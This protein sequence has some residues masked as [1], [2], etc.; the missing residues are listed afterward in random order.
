MSAEER[1]LAIVD[2]D[3]VVADVRHRLKYVERQPKD[4]KRFFASAID[5][6]AHVEGLAV[7]ERLVADHE[8]VFLTGRPEHLRGDTVA[9]LDQHGLG[10][11]PLVMRREGDR[12]PSARAKVG[13]LRELAAGR[14]V[15][16][17]IDDDPEVVAEMKRAGYVTMLA[18][19]E[20]RDDSEA[21]SLRAAQE[22]DGRS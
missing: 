1:P 22:I 14:R 18:D 7:V 9:W 3:G 21:A 15:A 19:W 17:V 5:D 8:V 13:M 12:R 16:I 11:H 20:A 6:E 2:I 4:W 10:G